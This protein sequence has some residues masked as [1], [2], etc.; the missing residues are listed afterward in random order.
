MRN[1]PA[2]P[3]TGWRNEGGD[4]PETIMHQNGMTLRDYLAAHAP[5][6]FEEACGIQGRAPDRRSPE[7][8]ADFLAQWSRLRY[9]YADAML[10]AQTVEE[11][12]NAE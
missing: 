10:A 11:D 9:E 1:P 12:Q 4:Y 2:F 5:I 8:M 7:V 6:S 3:R